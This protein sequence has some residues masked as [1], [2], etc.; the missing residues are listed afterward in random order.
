MRTKAVPRLGI[1]MEKNTLLHWERKC[2]VYLVAPLK[3]SWVIVQF[4]T[5]KWNLLFI[6]TDIEEWRHQS[7]SSQ[8]LCSASDNNFHSLSSLFSK[9]WPFFHYAKAATAGFSVLQGGSVQPRLVLYTFLPVVRQVNCL[10][11]SWCGGCTRLLLFPSQLPV[12][13]HRHR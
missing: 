11:P 9:V 10:Q 4:K 8:D 5:A 6:L 2:A 13:S 7:T 12:S 1:E 3:P